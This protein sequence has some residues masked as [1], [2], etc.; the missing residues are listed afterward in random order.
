VYGKR[1]EKRHQDKKIMQGLPRET[2]TWEVVMKQEKKL[3]GMVLFICI[4]VILGLGISSHFNLFT[5]GQASDVVISK[6]T[7]ETLT[8]IND[9][10][11]E[12]SAAIKP[13]VVNISSTKTIKMRNMPSPFFNDPF[14]QDFFGNQFRNFQQPRERKESGLG[15]GVIVEK[16]GY[17]LTNNHVIAGADEIK[18]KLSDKKEY[19]GKVI[20]T[21]QKTD[22]AV[23][24]INADNL[25]AIK[26]GD[27]DKVKIGEM[28]IAIGNPFG[29]NQT[30][31]SGIVSAKGRANVGVADYEDFIQ[32]DAAINPGN[33]GG[34]LVNV[35]GELIGI[36]TAIFSMSGGYQG[37]GFAIPSNMA[38][39]VMD[40][41]IK[42]GKVV[43]GWLGVFIQ[44]ITP[45][46]SKQF[47]LKDEK[48]ALIGDVTEDSPAEK[49]GLQ[50]GD[51]VIEFDGKEVLDA[52][53][54]RNIVAATP[55]GKSVSIKV[56]RDGN[57]KTF[58][59][60]IT[61]MPSQMQSSAGASNNQ[62][63]GVHVQAL[64]RE[65]KKQL[66]VPDRLKGVVISDIDEVSPAAGTLAKGDVIIQIDQKNVASLKDYETVVSGIKSNQGI[67]M[68]IYRNGA[69]FYMTLSSR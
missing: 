22:L 41:L 20:G 21:D 68:L 14:F 32:T 69:T 11:A 26:L 63:K 49:V 58:K 56:L 38:K 10:M 44:P 9:A 3:C 18:V 42:N 59:I 52:T 25:P 67:L 35:K 50:R 57:P 29:L 51:I 39:V 19:K 13:A 61:E 66:D 36:N 28:V 33:S 65:L 23:I 6:E 46:L 47:N 7:V 40:N 34:A 30:V 27:S 12:L 64:T 60:T 43:R 16:D 8:K 31:T 37:V 2:I 48:G 62:L 5:H 54:L 17:I 53:S 1:N 24:K 55:P 15:S 4:G 45:E